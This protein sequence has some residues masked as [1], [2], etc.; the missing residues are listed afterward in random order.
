[1]RRDW[2]ARREREGAE[3][4]S[5][6]RMGIGGGGFGWEAQARVWRSLS[7][8][9]PARARVLRGEEGVLRNLR[10][11]WTT[12]LP[13]K[14]DAPRMTR[15]YFEAVEGCSMIVRCGGLMAYLLRRE[16]EEVVRVKEEDWFV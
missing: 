7:G 1:M 14:P 4:V 11:S 2:A 12:Y 10:D 3:E 9:R 13:V 8:F 15:S 5:A 6:W 16:K